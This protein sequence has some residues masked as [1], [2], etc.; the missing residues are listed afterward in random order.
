MPSVASR[1]AAASLRRSSDDLVAHALARACAPPAAALVA[2]SQ[3]PA[4][5][6]RLIGSTR[7]GRAGLALTGEDEKARALVDV[8]Q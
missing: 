1:A 2:S 5:E 3:T 6:R 8:S 7:E 4:V